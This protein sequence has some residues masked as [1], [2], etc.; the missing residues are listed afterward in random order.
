MIVSKALGN[1]QLSAAD[2]RTFHA[3]CSSD[4]K[5]LIGASILD[6][7]SVWIKS[8]LTWYAHLAR[9]FEDQ[10]LFLSKHPQ[11]DVRLLL[12][13]RDRTIFSERLFRG[14]RYSRANV[15]LRGFKTSIHF[16]E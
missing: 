6:W 14:R 11:D 10:Q 9:D 12:I 4:A 8:T 1:Y 16:V 13:W 3:R 2:T 7:G 15:M 5:R